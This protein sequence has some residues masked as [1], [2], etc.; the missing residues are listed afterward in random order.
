MVTR[1]ETTYFC[2]DGKQLQLVDEEKG[3]IISHTLKP[4]SHASCDL[5]DTFKIMKNIEDI[6]K[7]QLFTITHMTHIEGIQSKSEKSNAELTSG[8]TVIVT[9]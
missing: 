5:I 2:M 7:E 6:E 9:E 4:N 1:M 8:S 3:V